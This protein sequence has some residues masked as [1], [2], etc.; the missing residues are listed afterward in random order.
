MG[1]AGSDSGKKLALSDNAYSRRAES[2]FFTMVS[3]SPR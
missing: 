2:D 3:L 1:Y